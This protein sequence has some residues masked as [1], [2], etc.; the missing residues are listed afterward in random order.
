MILLDIR[1]NTG[2]V[3]VSD[4]KIS[5]VTVC[6]NS[7]ETI[8]DTIESVL[9]QDYPN[10]EHVIVDGQSTDSTMTIV[11]EYSGR[12]S[13]VVSEPDNGLY[14][15]MNKGVTLAAGDYIGILNSDDVYSSVNTISAVVAALKGKDLLLG[16]VEFVEDLNGKVLRKFPS[17]GF[18]PW[19]MR[20]GLMP[21]HPGAF[22]SKSAYESVGFYK[23]DYKISADFELLVRMLFVEKC[24]FVLLDDSLVRM[25]IGGVSTSGLKSYIQSTKE[26]LRALKENRIYSNTAFLLSRL[27]IKALQLIT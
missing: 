26:M 13:R 20:F 14:D 16:G 5:I 12:I 2:V 18:R 25:R 11:N 6:Y 19:S 7:E 27:P 21:P 15:A 24:S 4:I 3:E 17:K 23:Q 1:I 10:I 22:I 9:S 8:R